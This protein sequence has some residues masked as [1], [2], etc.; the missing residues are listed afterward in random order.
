MNQQREAGTVGRHS[1]G[2]YAMFA[3]AVLAFAL[4][5][6]GKDEPLA[7]G[8]SNEADP[9]DLDDGEHAD[10]VATSQEPLQGEC[11]TATDCAY[12]TLGEIEDESDCACAKCPHEAGAVSAS[13][14]VARRESFKRECGDWVKE[15]RCAPG[16]CE[17]PG[18]LACVKGVCRVE[19]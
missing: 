13:A 14:M 15:Y 16:F 4:A 8:G 17:Q 7:L 9:V 6:C 2:S 5:G 12:E 11:T 18:E 1:L 19:K 10:P 3:V